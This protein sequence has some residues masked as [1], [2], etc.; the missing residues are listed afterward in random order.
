MYKI[1]ILTIIILRVKIDQ[2]YKIFL[3]DKQ[4][5]TIKF[6]IDAVCHTRTIKFVH[7]LGILTNDS[8]NHYLNVFLN[9]LVSGINQ[10]KCE[11]TIFLNKYYIDDNPRRKNSNRR[12]DKIDLLSFEKMSSK[13][14]FGTNSLKVLND[15][16]NKKRRR[17]GTSGGRRDNNIET[18]TKKNF[19]LWSLHV[20]LIKDERS[21]ERILNGKESAHWMSRLHFIVLIISDDG[22]IED[23]KFEVTIERTLKMFWLRRQI[24]NVLVFLPLSEKDQNFTYAYNPFVLNND[25]ERGKLESIN[26]ISKEDIFQCLSTLNHHRTD[27][28]YGYKLNV[29]LFEQFQTL[30]K[31]KE[32]P[33]KGSVYEYSLGYQ[34]TNAMIMGT[35]VKYMNFTA[36]EIN[37]EDR[38]KFGHELPNGTLD[39]PTYSGIWFLSGD[40][41]YGRA[42]VTFAS[43]FVKPYSKNKHNFEFT[44]QTGYDSI[45]VFVPKARKIPKWLRIHHMFEPSIWFCSIISPIIVYLMCY[46]LLLF[47]RQRLAYK[48]FQFTV[49]FPTKLPRSCPE[50]ILLSTLSITNVTIAGLFGGLLY[51]S[52]TND[53]YYKDIDLLSELDASGL[54]IVFLKYNLIDAFDDESMGSPVFNNLRKKFKYGMRALHDATFFRNASGL[55]RKKHYYLTEQNLLNDDL[56]PKLHLV[57]ECP[58]N[59]YLAYP[60]RKNSYLLE[61]IDLLIGRL[62]QAGLVTLWNNRTV[63]D[64]IYQRRKVSSRTQAHVGNKFVPFT[65]EDMQ[66]S[67]YLLIVGLLLSS[68]VFCDE[69]GWLRLFVKHKKRRPILYSKRKKDSFFEKLNFLRFFLPSK[70]IIKD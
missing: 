50:R 31:T 56:S 66:T 43:F 41:A 29:G 25:N 24:L 20:I 48:V 38:I 36:N 3:D 40:I 2:G 46:V 53:I 27:N 45:C 22:S 52:L 10:N 49:G 68:I 26:V 6:W 32:K 12:N 63:M 42:D 55:I 59:Y 51:K 15:L 21:M 9:G 57:K 64:L 14:S 61:K 11:T 18:R 13:N 65:L 8:S 58:R 60:I 7:I 47:T 37:P 54:P 33:L 5:N 1:I 4:E 17:K 44:S 28:L 23:N 19:N 35:I 69:K 16:G 34:G 67:F 39:K 70:K 62:H 30:M